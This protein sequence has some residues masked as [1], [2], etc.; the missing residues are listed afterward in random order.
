MLRIPV[1]FG[2]VNFIKMAITCGF[3]RD[4]MHSG[5]CPKRPES[6]RHG[7]ARVYQD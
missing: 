1:F 6:I 4:A 7:K 5:G 3:K 2:Q